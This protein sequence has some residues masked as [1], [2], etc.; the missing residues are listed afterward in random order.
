[1]SPLDA[2]KKHHVALAPGLGMSAHD[3]AAVVFCIVGLAV[4]S[5]VDGRLAG[6]WLRCRGQ[7]ADSAEVDELVSEHSEDGVEKALVRSV[8]EVECSSENWML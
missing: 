4:M 7:G 5:S 3:L 1:M 2:W 6:A 8:C